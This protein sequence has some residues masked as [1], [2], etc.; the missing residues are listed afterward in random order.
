MLCWRCGR[1]GGFLFHIIYSLKNV[2]ITSRY[3]TPLK[4]VILPSW[5]KCLRSSNVLNMDT[6]HFRLKLNWN[7]TW[8]SLTDNWQKCPFK[9][10]NIVPYVG[11]GSLCLDLLVLLVWIL[12]LASIQLFTLITQADLLFLPCS[13]SA[14][15]LWPRT[16]SLQ[17]FPHDILWARRP[18][19][20]DSERV[21]YYS[22]MVFAVLSIWSK[23]TLHVSWKMENV[24][25]FKMISV[26]SLISLFLF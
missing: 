16:G 22:P 19:R 20:C 14:S 4:A 18:A 3:L 12:D 5:W 21:I 7:W 23:I 8:L 17:V 15:R 1:C 13:L 25:V 11:Q 6:L 9:K 2:Q 10:K 24:V 26:C